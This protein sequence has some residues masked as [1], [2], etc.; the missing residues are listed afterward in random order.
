LAYPSGM[1][2]KKIVSQLEFPIHIPK[3]PDRNSHLGGRS[4]Y[5]F[6]FDDN[7][8]FLPTPIYIFHR[9]TREEKR[10]STAQFAT[11]QKHLGKAG[12]WGDWE[13]D[14]C[15]IKG[16]FRRFRHHP[17]TGKLQPFEEDMH[18]VLGRPDHEWKGPSWQFFWHA[19]HNGRPLSLITARGHHPD[20][21]KTGIELLVEAGHLTQSPN[22][23]SLYPVSH[24]P[25]RDQLGDWERKWHTSQLKQAA[26]RASVEEA[27]RIYGQ[28]PH[29]RFGMSDDDPIN[30]ELIIDVMKE[31]K[32][33]YPANSFFVINTHAHK[34]VKQE[35]LVDRVTSEEMNPQQLSLFD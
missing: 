3:Q 13:I 26:I 19:V 30:V 16:S 24:Q 23:L 28:N 1:N 17:S 7:V 6:D 15:E 20:T 5:F 18:E 27:F 2:K 31:L 8:A 29:H 9:H 21:L 25:T 35:I 34:L 11:I 14:L 22:Y 4:F 10:L 33:R 12:E 32:A